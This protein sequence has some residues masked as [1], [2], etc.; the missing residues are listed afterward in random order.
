M[1]HASVAVM[2]AM[3]LDCTITHGKNENGKDWWEKFTVYG[4][5]VRS[6][7]FYKL[8]WKLNKLFPAL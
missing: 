3:I 6:D 7:E 1:S 4:K 2:I 8:P 5:D